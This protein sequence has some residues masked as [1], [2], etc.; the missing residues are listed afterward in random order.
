M[1]SEAYRTEVHRKAER[2]AFRYYLRC[3]HVP[4][5]VQEVLQATASWEALEKYSPD[6]PRAPRGN[7]DGGQWVE[8]PGYARP[9]KPGGGD[10]PDPESVYEIIVG[11]PRLRLPRLT[12]KPGQNPKRPAAP[13]P[14]T[15]EEIDDP[16]LEPVYVLEFAAPIAALTVREAIVAVRIAA[17]LLSRFGD[18][19]QLFYESLRRVRRAAQ[20]IKEYMGGQ[21]S[22]IKNKDGDF[23]MMRGDKKIRFDINNPHPHKEPHINIERRTEHGK[24]RPAGE[25]YYPFRKE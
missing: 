9:K 2:L 17:G 21:P 16:P 24:W 5:Q 15:V 23:V 7:P 25:K 3:G 22:V 4:P 8:V 19:A 11:R 12:P 18:D 10:R 13:R 14:R 1:T 6:Q 20:A